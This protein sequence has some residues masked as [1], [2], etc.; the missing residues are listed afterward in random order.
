[1]LVWQLHQGQQQ[2]LQG[3]ANAKDTRQENLLWSP[4]KAKGFIF[5]PQPW[6]R[7]S[8]PNEAFDL[9][10]FSPHRTEAS[11]DSFGHRGIAKAAAKLSSQH[12]SICGK[13][14]VPSTCFVSAALGRGRC[15]RG[16]SN[17]GLHPE[18][19]VLHRA[20]HHWLPFRT[21][22]TP[23]P[24]LLASKGLSRLCKVNVPLLSLPV[25]LSAAVV[26]FATSIFF[27]HCQFETLSAGSKQCPSYA[28][29]VGAG[30]QYFHTVG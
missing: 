25:A 14:A 2:Q 28:P 13:N 12:S 10:I 19:V 20:G 23:Q 30:K 15:Q 5:H 18:L 17:E 26:G 3:E 6:L 21:F 29:G 24:P 7:D 16:G 11:F 22:I 8:F 4:R 9:F 27:P 1:M